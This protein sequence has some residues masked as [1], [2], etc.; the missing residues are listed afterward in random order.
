MPAEALPAAVKQ[1]LS[2]HIQSVEQLEVLLLFQANAARSWTAAEVYD[3]VRSS[4][5]SV[6]QRLEEFSAGG[7]LLK[8]HEAPPTYRYSPPEDFRTVIDETANAYRTWRIRI[9][10]AIFASEEKD[11]ARSFADAFK[12]RKT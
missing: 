12:V 3:V 6:A 4:Q 2:Q 9:I 11:A 5:A 7:F 8:T 10:E 1:F